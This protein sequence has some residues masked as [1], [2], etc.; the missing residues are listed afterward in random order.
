VD[1]FAVAVFTDATEVANTPG[2]SLIVSPDG[3]VL[4]RIDGPAEA[5][6]TTIIDLEAI[7]ERRGHRYDAGTIVSPHV[8]RLLD[9]LTPVPA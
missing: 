7:A 5:S 4:V 8:L 3:K 9:K 2:G 6:V 1:P